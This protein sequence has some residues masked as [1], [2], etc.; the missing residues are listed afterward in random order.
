MRPSVPEKIPTSDLF[1]HRLDQMIN[2]RHELVK[3]SD[4]ID[5][6]HLENQVGVC[7]ASSG[8]P[9]VRVRLMVGLHLLKYMYDLSDEG[10]CERWEYDPY[11]QYFC[12]EVY[13]QHELKMERSSMSHWRKRV[14]ENFCESLLGE[15]LKV[16]LE[17]GVLKAKD[18][19]RVVV[20]TTVQEKAVTHP[21]DGKLYYKA[22]LGLKRLSDQLGLRLRQHYVRIGKK[23]LF[24][25]G[26]YIHAKQM[27]RMKRE[28]RKLRVYVGRVLRDI[29]RKRDFESLND[30]Q[31]Q[32]YARAHKIYCQEKTDQNKLY[33]WHAPEVECIG[34]GKLAKPY[35]FGCKVS[36]MTTVNRSKAGQ[37]VLQAKALPGKPYDGHTLKGLI[38][39][40]KKRSNI[41]LERVY[42]DKGYRGHKCGGYDY[43]VYLSGSRRGVTA[44][45]KREMKRRNVIEPV[46]GHVKH[47]HRMKRNHLLGTLGDK[48]N[49]L[50][51]AV[52]YN[53]RKLLLWFR[54]LF[55]AFL[56]TLFQPL[57]SLKINQLT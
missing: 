38:E 14:G 31:K 35:E 25:I 7:Y 47:E 56:N 49:A 43:Q 55:F 5:W 52:G 2:L 41:P 39:D 3:L 46:I 50:L 8:R 36:L 42:V 23:H 44:S 1:R 10:V 29:E 18:L 22:L 27:N 15:S 33:S 40:Y 28:T 17:S 57:F 4:V 45:I 54:Q 24:K 34:K 16:A 51:A 53:F 37:F 19:K 20:D 11:F 9:G 26:R 21:S 6:V 12:G 32:V 13:F 48:I 30:A